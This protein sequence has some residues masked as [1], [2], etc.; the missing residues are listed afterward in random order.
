MELIVSFKNVSSTSRTVN[1]SVI[2]QGDVEAVKSSGMLSR[3]MDTKGFL[4]SQDGSREEESVKDF[5]SSDESI[6]FNEKDA[7]FEF[8]GVDE[9]YFLQV[10]QAE[11][12]QKLNYR[13]DRLSRASEEGCEFR[14]VAAKSAKDLK[15][16]ESVSIN[17]KG[18]FGPKKLTF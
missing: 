6:L 17:F 9:H 18:F 4:Y 10:F 13:L 11:E 7:T 16:G 14:F 1:P 2:F 12:G 5:C 3:S 8:F 15:P